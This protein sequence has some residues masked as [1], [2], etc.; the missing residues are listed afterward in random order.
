MSVRSKRVGSVA[1]AAVMFV[2]V[3]VL[4]GLLA[5]GLV[6]PFAAMAGEGGKAAATSVELLPEELETP[7]QSERSLVLDN[8]G[9]VLAT[10]FEENRVYVPLEDIAPVMRQAQ[11]AIEDHR[12]YEHGAIDV[13][14]T[15][16]AFLQNSA[17][18]STQGGSS[19][20]QQYVKMVQVE[21]AK[22][23]GDEEG[24]AAAQEKSY[25][26]KLQEMRYAIAMEKR[27][28]KDQILEAYLNIAYFGDGAYGVEQASRHFFGKSAKDLEVHEAAMLA[29]LVQ[30][31]TATDPRRFPEAAVERRNEVLDR[32]AD[33]E[34]GIITP[35]QAEEAK[36]VEWDPSDV[37]V[38]PNGCVDTEFP[39]LC[40]YVRRTMLQNEALG[41]TPEEREDALRRG[42]LTI[43]TKIDKKSQRIAEKAISDLIDPADPV[44]STMTMV[45]PGTGLIVAMAQSRPEMGTKKGQTYYNY[46]VPL[47]L[48]GAEGFQAGSTFKAYVAAAALEKGVPMTKRYNSPSPMDFSGDSFQSC[49]GTVQVPQGYRPKNSTRSGSNMP[50]DY[51][52]AWSVNTYFLQLGRDVGMCDTS[53]MMDKLGVK[54]SDGEKMTSQ[55][56][57]FS[58][59]LGSVDVTPLSMTEAYSTLAADGLHCNPVIVDSITTAKG[60][61]IDVPQAGCEQ[62]IDKNVARGVTSLLKRVMSATGSPA[63][64]Y[65]G[66]DIAGKTGTTNST[67][68][69]W[70]CGY[71]PELAGCASIAIDKRSKYFK[72]KRRS[73]EYLR[74]PESGNL[75]AGSGGGDAGARIWKPAMTEALKGR[76]KTKFKQPSAT[77]REGK[78]VDVP[79]VVGLSPDAAEKKLTEAGFSVVRSQTTS[80]APRGAYLGISPT[81]QAKQ[82]STIYMYFSAGPPPPKPKPKPAPK[83]KAEDK[84]EEKKPAEDKP[85]E[86]S[87]PE[88]KKP[89]R[90]P[91][92]PD[93][94]NE[95][96]EDGGE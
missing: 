3:S 53:K 14:G 92:K 52:M 59:P 42:G 63:A 67:Q 10:F 5:A 86:E 23:N 4:M 89:E 37:K 58:L 8:E 20:T 9:K 47:S 33:E 46:A 61:E 94:P 43:R 83:P 66:H 84:P 27:F 22:I 68:A 79:S 80:N 36:D 11:V 16:R 55:S 32:M 72:G 57:I 49:E 12:F 44:I 75:I 88:E 85:E 18:G 54:L 29:G 90:K 15:L 31:P 50:M 60:K 35:E 82:F 2:V 76:K 30:N 74:L 28:S 71:S 69:V 70:F 40:D 1:Y 62:V 91:E 93:K 17:G 6:V 41:K 65:N 64:L 73:L 56:T 13:V 24:I 39:F 38:P 21:K 25:G 45:E 19:I 26:R 95:D 7:P 96:E 48:G 34:I 78:T 87:E 77:V 51:A 81:G